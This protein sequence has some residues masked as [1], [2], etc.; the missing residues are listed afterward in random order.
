M[1]WRPLRPLVPRGITLPSDQEISRLVDI[2]GCGPVLCLSGAG[3]STESGLSDYRSPGVAERR[4]RPPIQHDEFVSS[5]KVRRRYWARS[6]TGYPLLSQT[7]PNIAHL[8]LT[9][10]HNGNTNFNAHITQ[11]VDGLLRA[12]GI[13]KRGRGDQYLELHGT[14][15]EVRCLQ[16]ASCLSRAD[17]Q[18][19]L[20]A[21]NKDW[22]SYLDNFEYRPD[23]D[24]ELDD[25][26]V[27]EFTVPECNSCRQGVYMP[28]LVF[29]GGS[30]PRWV[31]EK[32]RNFVDECRALLVVGSTTTTYSSYS[33]VKRAKDRGCA[34]AIA[35]F[36]ATR[37]D[38]LADVKVSGLVSTVMNRLCGV[39]NVKLPVGDSN[40]TDL[41]GAAIRVARRGTS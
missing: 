36:G 14:I 9:A 20:H 28:S 22:M 5:A 38:D 12:A 25:K 33:L 29:N 15:T 13:D 2:L 8:A 26:H 10:L 6:Y 30:V 3:I 23:G 37:S 34:V 11:N 18:E 16:C 19:V 40:A 1:R 21:H 24:A 4:R 27:A 35:N 7:S 17:F 39:Y 32:A 31:A 41:H